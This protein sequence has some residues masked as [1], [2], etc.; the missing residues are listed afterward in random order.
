MFS[1]EFA[2]GFPTKA[3]YLDTHLALLDE[4]APNAPWMVAGLGVD[5]RPLIATAVERG[6]HVRVGLEDAPWRTDLANRAW[7]EEAATAI[8]AAGGEPASA[9]EVRAALDH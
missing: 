1:D 3:H 4:C 6:G 2:W 9:R 5:I 7:V 8:R